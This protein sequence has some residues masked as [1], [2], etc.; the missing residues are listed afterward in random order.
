LK[1]ESMFAFAGLWDRCVN[2]DTGEFLETYTIITTA[3]NEL[4]NPS[5]GPKLHDRMPVILERE[6]YERWLAPCEP[7]HLPADL[8]RPYPAE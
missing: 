2:K 5:G 8:L 1:D 4:I 6:D 7:S 3:A